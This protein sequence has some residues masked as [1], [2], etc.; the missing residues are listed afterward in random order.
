VGE[1]ELFSGQRFGEQLS[2]AVVE[3]FAVF[4]VDMDGLAA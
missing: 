4:M 1:V 3:K 2:H